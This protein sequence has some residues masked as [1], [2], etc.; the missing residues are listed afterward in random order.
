MLVCRVAVTLAEASCVE[1]RPPDRL[2]LSLLG[3]PRNIMSVL[4]PHEIVKPGMLKNGVS[5]AGDATPVAHFGIWQVAPR[6]A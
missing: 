1:R 2:Y 3:V 5:I 6:C 4:L